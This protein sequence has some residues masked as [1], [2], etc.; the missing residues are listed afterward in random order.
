MGLLYLWDSEL[1]DI[2][3]RLG[4]ALL[5]VL[6]SLALLSH[7]FIINSYVVNRNDLVL[8]WGGGLMCVSE[9]SVKVG[10]TL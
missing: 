5:G 3:G 10:T 7:P 8:R 6:I 4:V 2:G 9:S 1:S